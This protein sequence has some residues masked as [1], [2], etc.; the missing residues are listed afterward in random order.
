MTIDNTSMSSGEENL[1][2]VLGLDVKE[3]FMISIM[4]LILAAV[5]L[6]L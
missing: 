2:Y 6:E 4:I 1:A 3:V 5:L